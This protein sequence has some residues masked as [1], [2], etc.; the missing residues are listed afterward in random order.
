MQHNDKAYAYMLL[1]LPLSAGEESVRPLS[2]HEVA[3]LAGRLDI[4]DDRGIGQLI[5]L[6]EIQLMRLFNIGSDEAYRIRLL[7]DRNMPLA[8]LIEDC[9][10][11]EIDIVTPFGRDYPSRLIRSM[12]LYNCPVLFTKGNAELLKGLNIGING[13]GG[14]KTS[15]SLK[16]GLKAFVQK[17]VKC[18]FGLI[19]QDEPGASRYALKEM[20]EVSGR[21]VLL[22]QAGIS[23]CESEMRSQA[24]AEPEYDLIISL[25][26]PDR[27][28]DA[29]NTALRTRTLFALSQAAFV[30]STDLKRGEQEAAKLRLCE[31]LYTLKSPECEMNDALLSKGF[32]QVADIGKFPVEASSEKW[33]RLDEYNQLSFI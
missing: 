8:K 28:Y 25:C 21:T 33:S 2:S 27:Q 26:H 12:G 15:D 4:N 14:V 10:S 23:A 32:K 11:R 13:M 6:E 17:L 19:G 16:Q 31:E 24:A 1:T 9:I 18:G 22:A 3:L 30:L 5:G 20:H 29:G 7:L